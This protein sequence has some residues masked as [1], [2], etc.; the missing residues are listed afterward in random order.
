MPSP[1]QPENLNG[2]RWTY[3]Q[4]AVFISHSKVRHLIPKHRHVLGLVLTAETN[5]PTLNSSM[6]FLM[7]MVFAVHQTKL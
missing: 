3:V 5:E 1:A 4:C 2:V 6:E 7:V